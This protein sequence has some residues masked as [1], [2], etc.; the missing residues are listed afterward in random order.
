MLRKGS[1]R[2]L[3]ETDSLERKIALKLIGLNCITHIRDLN[4]HKSHQRTWNLAS[5]D[6]TLAGRSE[7]YVSE[8]LRERSTG[9]QLSG[10]TPFAPS[11]A[12]YPLVV[13]PLTLSG[14]EFRIGG[15][16]RFVPN[17]LLFLWLLLGRLRDKTPRLGQASFEDSEVTSLQSKFSFVDRDGS[18]E[19]HGPRPN[20]DVFDWVYVV[21][22]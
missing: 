13:G 11:C 20:T 17:R 21:L 6:K 18:G 15:S 14:A 8:D 2:E 1:D 7:L 5:A 3:A 16:L 22:F 12:L 19:P 4:L 10:P 9:F